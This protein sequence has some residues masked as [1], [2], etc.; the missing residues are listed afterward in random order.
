MRK[1]IMAANWK[2]NKTV[3]EA[4]AFAQ[5][6]A[7]VRSLAGK[8]DVVVCPPFT[9]LAAVTD[10]LKAKGIAVGAQNLY[11]ADQGAFTGEIS[12]EMIRSIGCDY[13]IL[14]HSERRHILGESNEFVNAKIRKALEHQL[15]PILCVGETLEERQSGKTRE[16]CETQLKGSLKDIPKEAAGGIVVAYEPVWAIGTGVNASIQDAQETIQTVRNWFVQ[17]Y[18]QETAS[19]IRI[20]YGG[21]VKPENAGEYMG[22]PDIDGAL[23]GGASLAPDSFLSIVKGAV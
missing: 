6:M 13:V 20:Q 18:G 8:A 21:S 10:S 2:M 17:A 12:P 5:S 23:V 3:P 9:C 11:P 19:K 1:P 7:D 15:I 14:G 16:V 4:A 22:Q